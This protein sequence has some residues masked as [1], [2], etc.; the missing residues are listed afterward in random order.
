MNTYKKLI[1]LL[2]IISYSLFFNQLKG[3]DSIQS[4]VDSSYVN[5]CDTVLYNNKELQIYFY[6]VKAM[7]EFQ[8]MK[9]YR[10]ES[11]IKILLGLIAIILTIII[12]RQISKRK[13]HSFKLIK[14]KKPEFTAASTVKMIFNYWNISDTIT[15]INQNLNKND[16]NEI[17][18]NDIVALFHNYGFECYVIKGGLQDLAGILD[19]PAIAVFLNHS[20]VIYKY[21]KDKIYIADAYYGYLELN[22]YYFV[23]NWFIDKKDEKGIFILPVSAQVQNKKSRKLHEK[24]NS[25]PQL[26]KRYWKQYRVF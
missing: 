6:H 24:A 2:V 19:V 14:P 21:K 5:D 25:L 22:N 16:E 17:L 8:E 1:F 15:N 13:E 12:L 10:Y 3:E 11:I 20:S 23:N 9:I 26:E 18:L 7:L 4:T